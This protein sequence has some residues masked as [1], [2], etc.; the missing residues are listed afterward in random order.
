[1]TRIVVGVGGASGSIYAARLLS[2]FQDNPVAEVDVVFTR[3]ARLVW[4]DEVV[5]WVEVK[6]IVSEINW[7]EFVRRRLVKCEEVT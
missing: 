2:F 6:G 3:T 1:M 4:A 5:C 7:T